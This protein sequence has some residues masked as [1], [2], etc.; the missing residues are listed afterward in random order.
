MIANI[1]KSAAKGLSR[2]SFRMFIEQQTG[3]RQIQFG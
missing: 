1:V 2:A 3:K